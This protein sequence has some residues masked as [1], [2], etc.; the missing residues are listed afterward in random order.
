[1]TAE[2]WITILSQLG[3]AGVA[4]A[5]IIWIIVPMFLAKAGELVAAILA[6]TVATDKN[7]AAV[8]ALAERVSRLEGIFDHDENNGGRRRGD[9]R[10]AP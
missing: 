7:T 5:V 10:R 1:M 2:Q 6:G 3:V 8:A 9:G 4:L